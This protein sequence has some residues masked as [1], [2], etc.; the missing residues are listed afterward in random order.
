MDRSVCVYVFLAQCEDHFFRVCD[1]FFR[2]KTLFSFS[3]TFQLKLYMN[4]ICTH[5]TNCND[6]YFCTYFHREKETK[7]LRNNVNN[8]FKL[9]H[10]SSE[11]VTVW[12]FFLFSFRVLSKNNNG[13]A[14]ATTSKCVYVIPFDVYY[15][16]YFC[17]VSLRFVSLSC[18]LFY[19]VV[20]YFVPKKE[21]F[22]WRILK[23]RC[24]IFVIF[25]AGAKL[26]KVVSGMSVRVRINLLV[27]MM[28]AIATR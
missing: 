17:F 15:F 28:V 12:R 25:A 5:A 14:T 22:L 10:R 20:V 7:T 26:W 6:G 27:S 16:V 1:F 18:M 2:T 13:R 11:R 4:F 9:N 3:L 24:F 23:N 21:F 19:S 8:H